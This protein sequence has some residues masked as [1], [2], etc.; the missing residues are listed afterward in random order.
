M[1]KIVLALRDASG[2]A[3]KDVRQE[4]KEL[5]VH[6]GKNIATNQ[7]IRGMSGDI[8]PSIL[9]SAKMEKPANALQRM[10]NTTFMNIVESCSFGLVFP[11]VSRAMRE[12]THESKMKGAQIVGASVHLIS[13]SELLQPYLEE[14]M[15]LLQECLMHPTGG[16]QREAAKTFGHLGAG[17]P[18]SC[19]EELMPYLLQ[20]LQ[21]DD[22]NDEVSEVE[23]RGAADGLSEVWLTRRDLLP[24]WLYG[25][26]LPRIVKGETNETKAGADSVPILGSRQQAHL[27]STSAQVSGGHFELPVGALRGCNKAVDCLVEE[28]GGAY[29]HL[30]SPRMQE[31][32]FFE[33]EDARTMAMDLFL[34]LCEKI[35]EA[36]KY[37]QDFLTIEAFSQWQRHTLWSSVFIAGWDPLPDICRLA[38]LLWKEKGQSGQKA[39]T[40]IMGVLQQTLRA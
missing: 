37:G 18:S 1:L 11:I 13:E 21:S 33:P 4:E 7:E 36:V 28:F 31:A 16:I 23:R 17:L 6:M 14:L 5:L 30:L 10:A 20:Q 39:K 19:E 29:P 9:D 35:A 34:R 40:E 26:L 2:D 25:T 22:T 12:Q 3:H 32:L 38:T 27:P 15:P 8:L 24:S